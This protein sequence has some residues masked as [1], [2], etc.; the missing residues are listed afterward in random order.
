MLVKGTLLKAN[1]HLP[2]VIHQSQLLQKINNSLH[3]SIMRLFYAL[4]H[5]NIPSSLQFDVSGSVGYPIQSLNLNIKNTCIL[6][7]QMLI[8][9]KISP[10]H[11]KFMFIYI[12]IPI[13]ISIS[14]SIYN[15]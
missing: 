12:S 7:F 8:E 9:E 5:L 3:G 2:P 10:F 11:L 14:I 6:E 4:S 1:Y 13:P 15:I